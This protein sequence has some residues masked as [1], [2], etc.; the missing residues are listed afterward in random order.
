M[1][2]YAAPLTDSQ[3]QTGPR[4]LVSNNFHCEIEVLFQ[5]V[6]MLI[7]LKCYNPWRLNQREKSKGKK[8]KS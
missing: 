6:Q 8:I 4:S 2:A 5:N 1:N 7:V 3:Q